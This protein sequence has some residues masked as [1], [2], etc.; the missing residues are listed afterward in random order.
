M[1]RSPRKKPSGLRSHKYLKGGGDSE[2]KRNVSEKREMSQKEETCRPGGDNS[3]NVQHP[4]LLQM[5]KKRAGEP[6]RWKMD[7]LFIT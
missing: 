6:E 2:K 3:K 1:G 5:A 4:L 7:E